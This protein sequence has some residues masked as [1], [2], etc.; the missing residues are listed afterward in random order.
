MLLI[1]K[2]NRSLFYIIV[3]CLFLSC[4]Q[5]KYIIQDKM[6]KNNK[7]QRRLFYGIVA[8]LLFPMLQIL[9]SFVTVGKLGGYEPIP[10]DVE[11]N[12]KAWFDGSFQEG[13]EKYL[14]THFGFRN[15]AL[16]LDHQVAYSV[17]NKSKVHAVVIGQENYLFDYDYILEHNGKFEVK[18]FE[19]NTRLNRFVQLQDTLKKLGKHL[20]VVIGP[21]KADYFHEYLPKESQIPREGLK[22][23]Y[24]YYIEGMRKRN[25]NLVDANGWFLAMKGKAAYP[26][27]PQTGIHFSFYGAALF[28]DS[29]ISHVEHALDKDLPDLRWTEMEMAKEPREE[30]DDL[31]QAL[32][33]V[34]NIPSYELP[35]PK[36]VIDEKGKYKP[37]SLTIGDSF[38]WR[39]VNW[40]GL[41]KVW[42]NGQFWYY[43]RDAHPSNRQVANL[44]F[45]A[46]IEKAEVICIL[47][48]SVNLWRFGFG[49]D[50]QLYEHFFGDKEEVVASVPQPDDFDA[51]VARK[52]EEA[53]ANTEWFGYIQKRANEEGMDV[54][55]AL[56]KEAVYIVKME[57]GMLDD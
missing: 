11:F 37:R 46:E 53:R 6:I 55:A 54:E 30:D 18:E 33:L 42:N 29:I 50:D 20:M 45:A 7:L 21:N 43:N 4:T 9:F 35:Y 12:K 5:V 2:I 52:I 24:D 31:E 22:T 38:Y 13:K 25:I 10:G 28:A 51:L 15:W 49:F 26:L 56:R 3:P 40:G 17:Y 47:M 19:I 48:A 34:G 16:R 23:N 27:F 8:L 57:L 32:N 14:K 41:Q 36:I 1:T 44:D 39:F